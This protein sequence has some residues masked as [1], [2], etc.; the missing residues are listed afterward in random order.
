MALRGRLIRPQ[1]VQGNLPANVGNHLRERIVLASAVSVIRLAS[2]RTSWAPAI[3]I[4]FNRQT[5][6]GTLGV[7]HVLLD[8]CRGAACSFSSHPTLAINAAH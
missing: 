6:F 3:K 8:L 2:K 7:T 1:E 5:L 4:L